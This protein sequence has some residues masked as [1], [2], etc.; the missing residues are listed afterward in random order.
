MADETEGYLLAHAH[1]HQAQH[2]AE[3]LCALMPWLTTA[4]AEELTAF[5]VHRRLDVT[6]Q[7]MLGTVR[8]AAELRQEYESRY[9]EL[10]GVLLRRHAA[11]ACAVLACAA[12]AGAV[13]GVFIR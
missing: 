1:R 4:Q 8:R 5:Y 10:R 2:E 3:E 12:G 13:A 6:R 9:A 11:G 7:L